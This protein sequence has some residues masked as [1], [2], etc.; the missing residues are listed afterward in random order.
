MFVSIWMAA[1]PAQV[2]TMKKQVKTKE[3]KLK[4]KTDSKC[5]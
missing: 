4:V 3:E 2:V 5:V 1:A